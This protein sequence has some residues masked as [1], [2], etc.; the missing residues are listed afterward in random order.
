MDCTPLGSIIASAMQ[1]RNLQLC[2]ARDSAITIENRRFLEE[3]DMKKCV[4]ALILNSEGKVFLQRRSAT[5][6][7]FPGVWDIVGGHVEEGES[8]QEALRREIEEETGWTSLR[9]VAQVAAWDWEHDGIPRN[10]VDYL[11][12]VE[13]DLDAPQLELGKHDAHAWVGPDELDL[14][15]EG[16]YPADDGL[17]VVVRRA[18]QF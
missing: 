12:E 3:L 17:L 11:V 18:L 1:R 16:R 14:L 5:R 9:V 10:E 2:T 7:M 6:R 4:G 13:G 8:A 15:V